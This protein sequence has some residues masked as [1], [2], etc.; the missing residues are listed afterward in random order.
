MTL[1]RRIFE[2][3]LLSAD[4][5]TM[6]WIANTICESQHES[7]MMDTLLSQYVKHDV[8]DVTFR[9]LKCDNCNKFAIHQGNNYYLK[10]CFACSRRYCMN[11][12]D[13]KIIYCKTKSCCN[14]IGV[15]V[16]CTNFEYRCTQC[17]KRCEYCDIAQWKDI[18][19]PIKYREICGQYYRYM[20]HEECASKMSSDFEEEEE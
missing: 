1:Q 2:K 15:C 6:K 19:R 8:S 3:F 9:F 5:Q 4:E 7:T 13:F 11:C 18:A 16:L 20:T 10:Q 14:H 12:N 17:K